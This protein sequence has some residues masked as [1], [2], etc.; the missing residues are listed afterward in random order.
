MA[1]KKTRSTTEKKS[2]PTAKKT[3]RPAAKDTTVTRRA[4]RR[5]VTTRREETP[6]PVVEST[7]TPTPKRRPIFQV[8]TWITVLL[9]I[10]IIELTI[11]FNREKEKTGAGEATPTLET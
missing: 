7:P 9:L 11:Y 3:T 10:A 6:V 1:E 4:T 2:P 8:G 5:T